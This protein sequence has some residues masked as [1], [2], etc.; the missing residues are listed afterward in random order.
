MRLL[1]FLLS[2]VNLGFAFYLIIT[3]VFLTDN[4]NPSTFL[5]TLI[6]AALSL[7]ISHLYMLYLSNRID[8]WY[9]VD[10]MKSIT[11]L[12]I[13]SLAICTLAL[14]GHI[15][16]EY[17]NKR[18][19]MATDAESIK[20]IVPLVASMIS[21]VILFSSSIKFKK[22]ITLC[23]SADLQAAATVAHKRNYQTTSS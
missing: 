10:S 16:L 14:I 18:I 22:Y 21:S 6:Y 8:D 5:W 1:Q 2:L 12:S 23:R 4:I 3:N 13:F 15:C 11:N 7:A 20:R 9:D 17:Y 19:I